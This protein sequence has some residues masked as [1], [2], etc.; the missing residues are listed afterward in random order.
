[1]VNLHQSPETCSHINIIRLGLILIAQM[2]ELQ[3]VRY[4]Y[5]QLPRIQFFIIV[6]SIYKYHTLFLHAV[7][8]IQ[9][10]IFLH[11]IRK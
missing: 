3:E 2:T 6:T 4:P 10:M 8:V 5:S 1:M 11:R 7:Y 9:E